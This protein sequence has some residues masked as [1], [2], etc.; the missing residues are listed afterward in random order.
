M[1]S[2]CRHA[3]NGFTLIE[4]L[5]A[6]A[7]V[8]MAVGALLGTITSAASNIIYLRDK[9][10]AEWVALDRLTEIRIS[11]Q[12][13]DPGKR[14]GSTTMAGMRW[15]WE[16]EVVEL[17][18]KGMFRVDVHSRSTGEAVDDS[19]ETQKATAQKD[20]DSS[21]AGSELDNASWM[22]TVTGVVGSARSARTQAFATPMSGN[23]TLAPNK[24]SPNGTPGVPGTGI[25][26]APGTG[27]PGTTTGT[28]GKPQYPPPTD[29]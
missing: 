29:R 2:P 6:L 22:T 7:I 14:S 11:Q 27:A 1:K 19:H 5:I 24:Q 12:M 25:P 8:A 16:E 3:Q 26:G 10:L 13:P 23:V 21:A 20:P 9:T 15:Q 4:V 28:P 17:P 18:V